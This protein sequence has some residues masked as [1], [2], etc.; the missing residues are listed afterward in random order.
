MRPVCPQIQ[1]VGN[2]WG[3]NASFENASK[4]NDTLDASNV[5][6]ET[7]HNNPDELSELSVPETHFDRQAQTHHNCHFMK[8][9]SISSNKM[10]IINFLSFNDY[11]V[12][13]YQFRSCIEISKSHRY[14][15]R[16]QYGFKSIFRPVSFGNN[17]IDFSVQGISPKFSVCVGIFH[18]LEDFFLCCGNLMDRKGQNLLLMLT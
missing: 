3:N 16:F 6:D 7:R 4:N 17:W 9:K 15:K 13:K 14:H 18:A 1:I 12:K 8:S 10:Q 5:N 2:A 11:W